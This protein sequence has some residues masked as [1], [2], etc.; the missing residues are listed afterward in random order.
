MA[1]AAACTLRAA[2]TL[3]F[4][5]IDVEGGGGTLI[6][7]PAGESILIDSGWPAGSPG[8]QGLCAQ[9]IHAAA[10]A[11]GVTKIDYFILTHYHIDHFGG[12]AD[13]AKL[14]PI[15][16]VLDNGIPDHDPD[17]APTDNFYT[18]AIQPYRDF[19]AD[20]RQRVQPGQML[21]LKQTDG[22]AP[23]SFYFVGARTQ[24]PTPPYLPANA[25]T[26]ALCGTGTEHQVDT[27]DNANSVVMLL[28]FGAFK[29]FDGGDLTWNWEAKLVCPVNIVGTVDL[30]QVDH[31][32]LNLSNNPLLVRS[33]S[34]TVSV[35]SNAP[36]KGAHPETLETLRSVPTLQTMWQIHRNTLGGSNFNTATN[37]IANL[38]V[39]CDGNYIKCSVDPSG[40]TYTVSIP[41]TGVSQTYTTV[42]DRPY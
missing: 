42:L 21:P 41:A 40:K 34:P 30:Y 25:P 19:K 39:A 9:R 26:N 36:R 5:W 18:N 31:H 20:S 12:V 27:T 7:T 24:F 32:G 38:P 8:K 29:F 4:Y 35:M 14:M 6:V 23:L 11:A 33:L 13:V 10:V 16:E 3:D 22:M 15:G 17:H 37:Y 2:G 1:L 28:R